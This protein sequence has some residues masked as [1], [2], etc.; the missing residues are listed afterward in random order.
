[1]STVHYLYIGYFSI[2]QQC[3]P[4]GHSQNQ[5]K[6]IKDERKSEAWL[7]PGLSK[8]NLKYMFIDG[9]P[10]KAKLKAAHG[11]DEGK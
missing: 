4:E 9:F 7:K 5:N 1:M 6:E 10:Q 8:F 2:N 3:Q 11:L